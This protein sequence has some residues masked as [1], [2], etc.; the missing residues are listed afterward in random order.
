MSIL[1]IK[2]FMFQEDI[3]EL[4]KEFL[5]TTRSRLMLKSRS[6]S[7]PTLCGI[8]KTHFRKRIINIKTSSIPLEIRKNVIITEIVK[9]CEENPGKYAE[10]TRELLPKVKDYA[11]LSEF[12]VGQEVLIMVHPNKGMKIKY[13]RKGIVRSI[14]KTLRVELYTYDLIPSVNAHRMM[15]LN[16]FDRKVSIT[17]RSVVRTK[18]DCFG[19]RK[20]QYFY[21]S[22]YDE[23]DLG[24]MRF[25]L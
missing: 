12:Q 3:W 22:W 23:F 25:T 7:I 19:I 15:W 2:Q 18:T 20:T 1:V 16:S 24:K 21:N 5:I 8:F 11:W 14:G 6:L 17:D 9:G 10:I 4:I 13:N